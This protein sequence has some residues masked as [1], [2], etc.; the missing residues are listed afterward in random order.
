MSKQTT[1][2]LSIAGSLAAL[3]Y[4]VDLV[5]GPK[6][7]SILVRHT[8]E[9]SAALSILPLYDGTTDYTIWPDDGEPDH[10]RFRA[11]TAAGIVAEAQRAMTLHVSAL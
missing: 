8:E 1:R 4:D 2:T 7:Q 10:W 3:G 5:G 9:S 6:G 11:M